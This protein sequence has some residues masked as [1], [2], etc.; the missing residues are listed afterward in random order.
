MFSEN[1]LSCGGFFLAHIKTVMDW[2]RISPPWHNWNLGSDKPS[3]WVC[4]VHDSMLS[5]TPDLSSLGTNNPLPCPPP[6]VT[7]PTSLHTTCAPGQRRCR[8]SPTYGLML[9]CLRR[10]ILSSVWIRGPVNETAGST[11]CFFFVF[12][13]LGG[14]FGVFNASLPL[15]HELWEWRVCLPYL[16]LYPSAGTEK[17]LEIHIYSWRRQGA[18][19]TLNGGPAG[20][21]G[22]GTEGKYNLSQPA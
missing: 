4:P 21:P 7:S 19:Q 3:L 12:F 15:Q 17:V 10:E 14:G 6:A 13:F 18:R 20:S 16:L 8:Q 22:W 1:P 9:C 11:A 5:S 2:S